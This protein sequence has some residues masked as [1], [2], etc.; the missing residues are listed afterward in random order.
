[1][2]LLVV[3]DSTCVVL[4]AGYLWLRRVARCCHQHMDGV[5]LKYG[6]G[7]WNFEDS[8]LIDL[9][10]CMF[11]RVVRDSDTQIAKS[12]WRFQSLRVRD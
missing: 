2:K 12:P 5:K 9:L 6:P 10:T 3:A 7:R 4:V 11:P 8:L 1:M